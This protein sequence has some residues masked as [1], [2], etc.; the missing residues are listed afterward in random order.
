MNLA[1][2]DQGRKGK[3]KDK[4]ISQERE[5]HRISE[6]AGQQIQAEGLFRLRGYFD[7]RMLCPWDV[8]NQ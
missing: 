2:S 5:K 4:G 3:L 6:K 1:A 8:G 7:D